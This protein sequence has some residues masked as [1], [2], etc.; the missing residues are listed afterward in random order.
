MRPL[1]LPSFVGDRARGL[2]RHAASPVEDRDASTQAIG[3]V[4]RESL[5]SNG[6]PAYALS[7]ARP[8]STAEI[9][10]PPP[11]PHAVLDSNLACTRRSSRTPSNSRTACYGTVMSSRSSD[12]PVDHRPLNRQ[13]LS[14]EPVF[15]RLS[16]RVPVEKPGTSVSEQACFAP[17][18]RMSVSS[19]CGRAKACRPHP[20]RAR[21]GPT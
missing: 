5:V 17:R 20:R 6:G 7:R 13:P 19:R 14:L 12:F 4:Y 16:F 15:R 18:A 10:L 21:R 9:A 2:A 11:P 3:V 1:R 8:G